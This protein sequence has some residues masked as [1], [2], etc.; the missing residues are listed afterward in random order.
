MQPSVLAICAKCLI[1]TT[2]PRRIQCPRCAAAMRK[3]VQPVPVPQFAAMDAE[4]RAW[5]KAGPVVA[6]VV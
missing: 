1:G 4:E 5:L 2:S 6:E 3:L